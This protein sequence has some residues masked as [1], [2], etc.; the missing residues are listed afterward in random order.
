MLFC[1]I[2]VVLLI[3]SIATPSWLIVQYRLSNGA[4]EEHRHGLWL[5]CVLRGNDLY[6]SQNSYFPSYGSAGDQCEYK[7]V[8]IDSFTPYAISSAGGPPMDPYY[9]RSGANAYAMSTM[10]E[11]DF[12]Q[13]RFLAWHISTLV[14]LSIAITAGIFALF[15]SCCVLWTAWHIS[16]LVLLSIAITAG[17]FALFASCC[18]LWTGLCAPF[19]ATLEFIAFIC[20]TIG[21]II[22]FINANRP[23]IRY[24]QIPTSAERWKINEQIRGFS[25]D[26]TFASIFIFLF[27]FIIGVLSTITVFVNANRDHHRRHLIRK[28]FPKTEIATVSSPAIDTSSSTAVATFGNE[29]SRPASPGI[30]V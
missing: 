21:C 22:F 26:L 5:D 30:A 27:A 8:N 12:A 15:A 16:T 3:I 6:S 29:H 28:T 9:G 20:S 1:L 19:V 25:F 14:L 11:N 23:E 10:F 17:I 24:V 13:H 18:V 2:G 4:I 7:W